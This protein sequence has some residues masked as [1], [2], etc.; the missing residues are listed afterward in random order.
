MGE[1]GDARYQLS[2]L[3]LRPVRLDELSA[4]SAGKVKW[5]VRHTAIETCLFIESPPAEQPL[6]GTFL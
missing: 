4:S 5:A 3:K 2:R 1:N 6:A